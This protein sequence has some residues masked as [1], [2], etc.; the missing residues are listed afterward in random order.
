MKTLKQN[1]QTLI[2]LFTAGC[3]TITLIILINFS[4]PR[5]DVAAGGCSV[6]MAS[7]RQALIPKQPE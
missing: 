1:L 6:P 2:T 3:I 7:A 4:Q 5:T